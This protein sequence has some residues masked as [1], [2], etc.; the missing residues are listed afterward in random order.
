[1]AAPQPVLQIVDRGIVDRGPMG[2]RRPPRSREIEFTWT[3]DV[4]QFYPVPP[5]TLPPATSGS[6]NARIPGSAHLQATMDT[7]RL[8]T[9]RDEAG[10]CDGEDDVVLS[11]YL[12][13]SICPIYRLTNN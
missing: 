8:C 1:M 9:D 3:N 11:P 5:Q 10:G 6:A 4:R 13:T 7:R 2:L 12:R